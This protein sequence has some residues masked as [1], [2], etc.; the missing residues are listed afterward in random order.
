M[1]VTILEQHPTLLDQM[2]LVWPSGLPGGFAAWWQT[3]IFDAGA[4]QGL[5]ATNA[6]LSL[7]P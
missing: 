7:L 2:T 3:W 6:V 5:A 4:V 1:L